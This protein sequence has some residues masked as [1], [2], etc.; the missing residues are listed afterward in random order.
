MSFAV[1][2]AV[3]ALAAWRLSEL[4]SHEDGPADAIAAVRRRVGRLMSCLPCVSV[5]VSAPL[6]AW[7]VEVPRDWPAVWLAI[8]GAACLLERLT[9]REPAARLEVEDDPGELDDVLL[10]REARE[11]RPAGVRG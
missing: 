11:S 4:L 2:F 1:R 5:W 8:S 10:R 6:A 3:A 9:A 7:A